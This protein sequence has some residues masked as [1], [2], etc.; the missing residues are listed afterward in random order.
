MSLPVC[1]VVGVGPG[2]GAAFARRFSEAGHRVALC[3]RSLERLEKLSAEIP[4]S[5]PYEYDASRPEA[6]GDVFAQIRE[7]LGPITTLVYN[8]GSAV[9]GDIDA[10]SFENFRN[11]WEINTGGLFQATK[12]VLPDMR[13]AG[14][15]NIVVIG[16]TASLKGSAGFSA[17]TSAK[18]G[19]RMLAQSLARKLGPEKIHV[20]Y[21]IIDG[22]IDIPRTRA[23][24]QDRPDDFFLKAGEIAEAVWFLTQQ[25]PSAWTFELDLRPFGER[26]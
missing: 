8:A 10:L 4:N 13:A 2:N 6:P 1:A 5:K 7:E 15:G 25:D 16:A 14:G 18:A 20:C 3:S 22:V 26:W 24:L 9:F 17:F 21:V 23:M 12:S 19:Q 11:A